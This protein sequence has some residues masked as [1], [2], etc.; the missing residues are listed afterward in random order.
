MILQIYL[1]DLK[2]NCIHKVAE[3]YNRISRGIY[4]EMYLL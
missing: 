3:T 4:L 2:M 1:N